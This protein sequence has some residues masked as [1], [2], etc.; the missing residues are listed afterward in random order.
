MH[1]PCCP[2]WARR[3]RRQPNTGTSAM[4]L[5][6]STITSFGGTGSILLNG[7][8]GLDEVGKGQKLRSFFNIGDARQRNAETLTAIHH[9]I[10]NDPRY[11]T[12]AV[13]DEAVRL[14]SQVR[15]DRAIGAAE[16]K[17]IIDRLDAMSTDGKRRLAA[18]DIVSG[19][20]AARGFPAFVPQSG[21]QGY[22][23]LARE[24]VAPKGDPAGGYGRFDYDGGLD[25][26][27]ARMGALFARIGDGAGDKDVLGAICG[28]A[29]RAADGGLRGQ[30]RLEEFVDALKANLD[31]SRALGL[32]YGEQTRLDVVA[33]IDM[34]E[35]AIAPSA[36]VPNPI[37]TLVEL[38][39]GAPMGK[40]AA[41]GANSSAAEINDAVREFVT[42]LTTTP[43]GISITDDGE[44]IAA[45]TLITRSAV[46]AMP[47]NVKANLL[48]ALESETGKNLLAF[49]ESEG[50]SRAANDVTTVL[51]MAVAQIKK[52][53]GMPNPDQLIEVPPEPDLTK[54]PPRI[55]AQFSFSSTVSGSGAQGVRAIVDRIN[56][57]GPAHVAERKKRMADTC[58]AMLVTH[59]AQQ[60]SE[61]LVD[62]VCDKSGKE[63]SRAFNPDKVG[64]QFDLDL[65][66]GM[67]VRLPG[68]T[69]LSSDPVKAR[70]ELVRFVTGDDKATFAKAD[71]PT[72]MKVRLISCCMHQATHAIAMGAYYESLNDDPSALMPKVNASSNRSM[73]R[74]EAF[75]L[76]KSAG[77]D[78]QIHFFSHRPISV[79]DIDG[80]TQE[81]SNESYDEFE[82]DITFPAAN[83]D[84]L[85]RADWE[86]FDYNPVRAADDNYDDP[87][88]HMTAANLVPDEFKFTGTV[89]MSPHLHIVKA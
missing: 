5:T 66:R 23:K 1:A 25:A 60:P 68:G 44:V 53:L 62:I 55:L 30:D 49:Y 39:R 31:E 47:D 85:S 82:M 32:Q 16:I 77:G 71:L 79:V 84:A 11:F 73:P 67:P 20:L 51:R 28:K 19:R 86:H 80:H 12:K 54:L 15:T 83:L 88:R 3:K 65:E 46:N 81:V 36:S 64:T 50:V 4:P 29:F 6:V 58:S 37:R 76:S 35:G 7:Q 61:D 18:M 63:V 70:D 87:S 72:K 89:A 38:G 75:E 21:E 13:Q 34:K 48:A 45:R 2:A 40:L 74:R 42:V 57:G 69:K 8:G 43:T 26:F 24:Q 10:I 27:E 17:S 56:E 33:M 9:A 78:V 59:I 41:L 22:T 14:L 52:S